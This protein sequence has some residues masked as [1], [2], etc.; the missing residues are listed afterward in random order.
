[1]RRTANKKIVRINFIDE[2]IVKCFN[3]FDSTVMVVFDLVFF[4]ISWRLNPL[5]LKK[6]N[7]NFSK[8]EKHK[9]FM[10]TV[11][12][13]CDKCNLKIKSTLADKLYYEYL[14][15]KNYKDLDIT[16]EEYII[17]KLLE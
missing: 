3:L 17:K 12:L 14:D 11:Y 8:I 6:F 10:S 1:M 9:N 13:Y 4:K 5:D 7:H 2:I 15:N 16:C